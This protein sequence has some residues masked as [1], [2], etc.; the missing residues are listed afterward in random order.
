MG[1]PSWSPLELYGLREEFDV[2]VFDL[3]WER[4]FHELDFVLS[5]DDSSLVCLV[6][7]SLTGTQGAVALSLSP[8]FVPSHS[9]LSGF[10]RLSSSVAL[11][12]RLVRFP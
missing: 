12:S 6:F 11:V 3:G 5:C 1:F 2:S 7:L 10:S 9:G 4:R 8:S